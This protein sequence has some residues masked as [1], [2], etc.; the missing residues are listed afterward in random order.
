MN[1][2]KAAALVYSLTNIALELALSVATAIVS[3]KL[4][5]LVLALFMSRRVAEAVHNIEVTKLE[6]EHRSEMMQ[7]IQNTFTN[8]KESPTTETY[9]RNSTLQ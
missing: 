1:K 8:A 9:E 3:Y 7:L 6:N 4:G 5:V 2:L